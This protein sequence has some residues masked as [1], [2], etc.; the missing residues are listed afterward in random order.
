MK[1]QLFEIYFDAMIDCWFDVRD[2]SKRSFIVTVFKL[3]SLSQIVANGRSGLESLAR[4]VMDI[5]ID[6]ILLGAYQNSV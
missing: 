2:Y 3:L 5:M 1:L 6:K 4:Y